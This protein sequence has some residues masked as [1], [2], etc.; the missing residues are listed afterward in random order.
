MTAYGTPSLAASENK[1]L[2]AATVVQQLCKFCRTCFVFYCMFYFTCDR[3]FTGQMQCLYLQ[4][5]DLTHI[6]AMLSNKHVANR[7]TNVGWQSKTLRVRMREMLICGKVEKK[8]QW[9]YSP[10][11][12]IMVS[13]KHPC[14]KRFGPPPQTLVFAPLQSAVWKSGV[15]FAPFAP[16][17][18]PLCLQNTDILNRYLAPNLGPG[19]GFPMATNV[20]LVVV[21]VVVVVVVFCSCYQIFNVLRLFH[22]IN[23][24]H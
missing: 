15:T 19:N 4:T 22:F 23:D 18:L 5:D 3:S 24:R 17:R 2:R 13:R 7:I 6:Q 16:Y 9:T 14:L 21:V 8:T 10:L 1:M 12:A 20:V 11:L